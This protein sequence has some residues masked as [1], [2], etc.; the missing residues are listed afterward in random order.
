MMQ[1]NPT[2][3]FVLA[4]SNSD[5]SS[6]SQQQPSTNFSLFPVVMTVVVTM[7]IVFLWSKKNK[8]IEGVNTL[9]SELVDLPEISAQEFAVDIEILNIRTKDYLRANVRA[10]IYVSISDKKE[11]KQNAQK[12][13]VEEERFSALA[14]EKAVEKRAEAAIRGS[15]SQRT[16]DCLHT[17]RAVVAEEA[18]KTLDNNSKLK[19]LGL[20]VREIVIGE[21]EENSNYIPNNYFDAQAIKARTEKIQEAIFETRQKELKTEEKIRKLELEIG[22][23]IEEEEVSYQEKSWKNSSKIEE[24]E[25]QKIDREF[26][27][28]KHQNNKEKELQKEIETTELNF[29]KEIE[30]LRAKTE[31]EIQEIKILEDIKLLDRNKDL[32][33]K[34]TQIHQE[35]ETQEITAII[36][37]IKKEQERLATEKERAEAQEAVTTAIEEAKAERK[38]KQ[39]EIAFASVENEAQIIERLAQA[40][41]KHYREIQATNADRTAKMIRELAPELMPQFVEI[42]KALAPQS[43]ILGNSN[44]Y[45][46]P[47]GN[48]E[49]INKLILSTSGM[50]PIQSL[51]DG[52]LGHLLGKSFRS[53]SNDSA[54]N[55]HDRSEVKDSKL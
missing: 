22:N 53:L 11:D 19:F 18:Q 41:G 37:I 3:S 8:L 26:N 39:V 29:R 14:V 44:I 49:E 55:G 21:I 43:G 6:S 52:K 17:N 23:K 36:E 7:I 13:L 47:N 34:Q 40:E 48:G 12:F 50:L 30:S 4:Q 28:E 32:Q 27:I 16:L 31:V 24:I 35:T 51:L 10:T 25:K 42:A 45:T 46:F 9:W 1:N 20:I 15:A 2:K 54:S 38:Q 33:L 5:F